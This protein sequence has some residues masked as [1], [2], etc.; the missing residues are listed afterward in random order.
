[1]SSRREMRSCATITINIDRKQKQTDKERRPDRGASFLCFF[2]FIVICD[3][4]YVSYLLFV[5]SGTME[6]RHHGTVVE[7]GSGQPGTA[8]HW[9]EIVPREGAD[10]ALGSPR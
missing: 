3:Y 2:I 9:G 5:S 10:S 7:A 4:V 6:R 8:H 1:M